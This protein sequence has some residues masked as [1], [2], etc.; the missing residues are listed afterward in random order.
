MRFGVRT[1]T[2]TRTERIERVRDPGRLLANRSR[3]GRQV[4]F[5]VREKHPSNR[6]EPN[7]TTPTAT[8]KVEGEE[9]QVDTTDASDPTVIGGEPQADTANA[10]TLPMDT[11]TIGEEA[12]AE[13]TDV[14]GLPV[15]TTSVGVD[16]SCAVATEDGCETPTWKQGTTVEN[17]GLRIPRRDGGGQL[18]PHGADSRGN[19]RSF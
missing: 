10:P 8:A 15:G 1:R 13:T 17:L 7:L 4:R 5:G 14:S 2:R 11:T 16:T 6:T 12:Q 3:T 19:V 18:D 9:T